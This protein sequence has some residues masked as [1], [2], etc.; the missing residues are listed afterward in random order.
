MKQKI[1]IVLMALALP[2]MVSCGD[3]NDDETPTVSFYDTD[4]YGDWFC[5]AYQEDGVDMTNFSYFIHFGKDSYS[6]NMPCFKLNSGSYSFHLG[7]LTLFGGMSY[8]VYIKE[9]NLTIKGKTPANKD[10][11]ADF[12]RF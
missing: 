11:Q 8:G 10:F 6:T 1:L 2:V 3:D 5:M 9:N 7:H 12:I 4:I